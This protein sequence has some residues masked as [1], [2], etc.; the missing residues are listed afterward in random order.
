LYRPGIETILRHSLNHDEA[1]HVLNDFHLGA[2]GGHLSGMATAHKILR[3]AYFWP[4]IFKYCIEV[5]KQ[6]PPYQVFHKKA[7]TH[8]APLHHVVS[9]NPFEKWGIDV[10]QCKPTSVGGHNNIIIVVDYFKK[11]VEYIHT[12]LNDGCTTTIFIF[13]HIITR[14]G[15]PESIV[16]D[17]GSHFQN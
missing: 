7:C 11:W 10:M 17:H 16:T 1:E 14:F 4:S 3:V 6:F 8:L 9:I 5:F 12:F 2:C 15:V 13:N